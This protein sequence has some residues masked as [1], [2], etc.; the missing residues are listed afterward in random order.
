MKKLL[1]VAIITTSI[2]TLGGCTVKK[3][4][5]TEKNNNNAQ[6][7]VV[8]DSSD[9]QSYVGRVSGI[10]GNE[11]SLRIAKEQEQSEIDDEV[12]EE[13]SSSEQTVNSNDNMETGNSLVAVE[14]D[15]DDNESFSE[16]GASS[17]FEFTDEIREIIIPAGSEIFSFLTLNTVKI[18]DIK[19]GNVI[20]IDTDSN[21]TII[22]VTILE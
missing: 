11:V 14:M 17:S 16:G 1:V 4:N 10:V 21:G 7:E 13:N 8:R 9:I 15:Q 3:D 22:K 20:C 12:Y 18:A 19:E 6:E 2:F 5:N